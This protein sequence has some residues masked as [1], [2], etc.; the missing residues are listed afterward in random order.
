MGWAG[1]RASRLLLPDVHLERRFVEGSS[2]GTALW[3]PCPVWL[4]S[5]HQPHR[6]K[7]QGQRCMCVTV[8]VLIIKPVLCSVFLLHLWSV[9]GESPQSSFQCQR[10]ASLFM[11]KSN[12]WVKVERRLFSKTWGRTS[13]SHMYPVHQINSVSESVNCLF[14]A[15]FKGAICRYWTVPTR[16]TAG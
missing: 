12:A 13:V 2:N 14:V 16:P 11:E 10:V 3:L 7:T 15:N 5:P 4:W 6:A 1:W 8:C 9:S